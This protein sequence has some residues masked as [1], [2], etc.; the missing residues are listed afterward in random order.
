MTLGRERPRA[1]AP[2]RARSPS[3]RF[4]RERRCRH[5][6]TSRRSTFP[7]PEHRP[8]AGTPRPTTPPVATQPPPHERRIVV[9]DERAE[10]AA[11]QSGQERPRRPAPAQEPAE[12]GDELPQEPP[13]KRRWWQF[14]KGGDA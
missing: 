4:L 14:G 10:E 7:A 3:G 12:I 11:V 6:T 8:P 5:T 2:S 9:I 1:I 13:R